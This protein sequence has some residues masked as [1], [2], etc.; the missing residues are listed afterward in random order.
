MEKRLC[1]ICQHS[2]RPRKPNEWFCNDCYKTW[3]T[4]ILSKSPWIQACVN[5]EQKRRRTELNVYMEN[6]VKR[7][8]EI[9]HV[10]LNYD[11]ANDGR[12]IKIKFED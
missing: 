10:G 11:I 3:Q 6:G 2:Y 4:E 9:V 5:T 1:A 7:R 12:L 8:A